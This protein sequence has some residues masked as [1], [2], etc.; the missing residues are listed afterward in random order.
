VYD[1]TVRIDSD[2]DGIADQVGWAGPNDGILA[3]DRNGDGIIDPTREIAFVD[4]LPGAFSDLEGLAAF[5][6]DANGFFGAG[7]E[8]FTEFRIWQDINQDGVSQAG[9]LTTLAERN[10]AAINLAEDYTG[11][12][13]IG[14]TDNVLYGTSSFIRTDGSSGLVGDVMFAAI[15]GGA[16]PLAAR[17]RLNADSSL[18]LQTTPA[19][20]VIGDADRLAE[21]DRRAAAARAAKLE[22]AASNGASDATAVKRSGDVSKTA[23]PTAVQQIEK[24]APLA[25]NLSDGP[26]I[27]NPGKAASVDGEA[28]VPAAVSQESTRS[29]A[30]SPAPM[31]A[32]SREAPAEAASA[33]LS[34]QAIGVAPSLGSVDD[35][36]V[37][38]RRP[39]RPSTTLASIID[40]F[41]VDALARSSA[42][43]EPRLNNAAR[44]NVGDAALIKLLDQMAAFNSGTGLDTQIGR[45][46]RHSLDAISLAASSAQ[47]VGAAGWN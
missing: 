26:T 15:L 33:G 27:P 18:T 16:K 43:G 45:A 14:A 35:R 47:Q 13:P 10:I 2:N 22:A 1:S 3:Y 32:N 28:S 25:A 24:A 46:E 21:I 6:S 39:L 36:S 5:D 34:I 41:S 4:D 20:A 17:G 31:A 37:A 44:P 19:A 30:S 9:E 42:G 40:A 23:V 7:D 8:R 38:G 11:Q 12:T 29:Y